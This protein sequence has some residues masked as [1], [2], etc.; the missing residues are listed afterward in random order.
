M[1]PRHCC[2]GNAELRIEAIGRDGERSLVSLVPLADGA[3]PADP[4]LLHQI[5]LRYPEVRLGNWA[6]VGKLEASEGGNLAFVTSAKDEDA[7]AVMRFA[8]CPIACDHCKL[9]SSPT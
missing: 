1:G 6:V 5:K 4:V 3:V 7:Q 8:A 2:P 9:T